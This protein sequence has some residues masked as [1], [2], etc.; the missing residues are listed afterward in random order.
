MNAVKEDKEFELRW[1]VDS[2]NPVTKTLVLQKTFGMK[3]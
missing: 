1:P 2:K 3:L